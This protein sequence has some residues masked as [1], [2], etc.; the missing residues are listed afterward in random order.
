MATS[1]LHLMTCSVPGGSAPDFIAKNPDVQIQPAGSNSSE[2]TC[3][4]GT[5]FLPSWIQVV[6]RNFMWMKITKEHLTF[7]ALNGFV[8]GHQEF[9]ITFH[10]TGGHL[11]F[12]DNI[13]ISRKKKVEKINPINIYFIV[14]YIPDSFSC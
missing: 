11:S 3:V 1:P 8:S 12:S 5:Q 9:P 4:D 7:C 14:I 2:K 6:Q 10:Q 13:Y